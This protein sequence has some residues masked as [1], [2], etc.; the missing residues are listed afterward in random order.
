MGRQEII[1]TVSIKY[2][3]KHFQFGPDV[4][5]CKMESLIVFQRIVYGRQR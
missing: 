4:C 3:N 2:N 5:V 1:D